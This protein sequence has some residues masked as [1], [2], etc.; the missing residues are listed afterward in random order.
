MAG[1][2]RYDLSSADDQD[3]KVLKNKLGI[4]DQKSLD[5]AEAIL[6]HDS[7]IYFFELLK[8]E[9][10]VFNIDL[11]FN[12]HKYFLGTL[13]TWAGKIR[14]VDISKDDTL[15]A[16][17][18]FLSFTL[19][20]FINQLPNFLPTEVDTKNEVCT[21]LAILHNELNIIH[22]F[23]EGNGRTIR[24]FLD[25]IVV[26]LGYVPIRWDKTSH[27]LYLQACQDGVLANHERMRRIIYRGLSRGKRK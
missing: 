7:Y 17:A 6:L 25:L 2:S 21:K 15:F 8:S 26:S 12:I 13:Y 22:P 1:R 23:R 18:K 9:K 14:T 10:V 19:N 16:S 24:L 3:Y 11:L 20:K 4:D 27:Y 5:D